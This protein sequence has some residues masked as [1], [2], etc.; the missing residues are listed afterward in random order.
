[1][2]TFKRSLAMILCVMMLLTA[3]PLTALAEEAGTDSQEPVVETQ[4]IVVNETEPSEEVEQPEEAAQPEGEVQTAAEA[5]P[6]AATGAVKVEHNGETTYYASL[7][8]AFDG[9]APSNNTYGGTYVV[10]LLEDVSGNLNKTL[11]YPTEVLNITLDLNGHTITGDGSSVAVVINFGAKSSA[12]CVFT[13]KDSSGNNSGKITGGK[14]GVKLDGKGSTLNFM[15][16]TITGNHGASKGGGI[17]MGATAFLNMTGGIITGN[18]VTGTSANSGLGGGVLANYATISGGAI[19]GNSANGGT[20]VAS[21]R[22]G[23]VCTEITRTKGYNT[24]TIYS[25]TVFGNTATNAGDDVMAQGNGMS[26]TKFSFSIGTENW[27]VDGWNGKKAS[28][29]NGEQPRYSADNAV[30]YTDGG[31]VDQYNK[32]IGLKYV[33]AAEPEKPVAPEAPTSSYDVS[34]FDIVCEYANYTLRY[35]PSALPAAYY[36]IGDVYEE[37]GEY[38]APACAIP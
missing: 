20:N 19:Y 11:S 9:F 26:T 17:F 18:S 28:A 25:G 23:G 38:S 15:G 35:S 16:G 29:G 27:F 31:W 4:D 22:G 36:S 10:T 33:V 7:Q 13:I 8:K 1:M 14:G 34:L 12:G 30:A 3:T 5:E 6:L 32:S 24:L 37:N 2:A 21:G